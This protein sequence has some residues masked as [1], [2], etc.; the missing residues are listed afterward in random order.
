MKH[1][2]L[3][4]FIGY[5]IIMLFLFSYVVEKSGYYEY[6]LQRQKV[7][8]ED[9]MKKFESDIEKGEDIDINNY[10]EENKINYSNKLTDTMSSVN[11][12]LNKYLKDTISNTF[13]ILGKLI[14]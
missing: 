3:L 2:R 5:S 10:L 11:I 1:K 8:T 9:S 4:K 13:K 6:N 7:L 12:S 14:N